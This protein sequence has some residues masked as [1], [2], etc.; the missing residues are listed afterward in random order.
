[1]SEIDEAIRAADGVLLNEQARLLRQC[2]AAID[3]I[4]DK[5]PM[6]G[7]MYYELGPMK[8]TL[9]NLRAELYDYRPQ[10]VF[11]IK[12]VLDAA[13]INSDHVN[14]EMKNDDH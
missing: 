11:G 12:Q 5:K 6:L 8:G 9:G 13:G 7:A 4:L 10:G 3:T 2:R 1:M 14:G